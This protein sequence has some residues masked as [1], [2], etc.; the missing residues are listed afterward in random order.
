DVGA[1]VAVLRIA[2]ALDLDLNVRRVRKGRL[3]RLLHEVGDAGFRIRGGHELRDHRNLQLY[4]RPSCLLRIDVDR[5]TH[6]REARATQGAVPV[7]QEWL[8]LAA[9][10]RTHQELRAVEPGLALER[11]GNRVEDLQ[12]GGAARQALRGA[13]RGARE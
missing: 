4:R 8:Q 3:H 12:G 6:A 2:R 5:P 1:E 7:V 13:R 10:S 9:R 11:R